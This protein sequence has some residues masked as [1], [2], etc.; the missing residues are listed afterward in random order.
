MR[1]CHLT[2]IR[3]LIQPSAIPRYYKKV[4]SLHIYIQTL[5]YS[6]YSSSMGPK[7]TWQRWIK[8]PLWQE[9]CIFSSISL[10][11]Y[12]KW[13]KSTLLI[14]CKISNGIKTARA[15]HCSHLAIIMQPIKCTFILITYFGC[16][17]FRV[18]ETC[19]V[20]LNHTRSYYKPLRENRQ[21]NW[22]FS[23]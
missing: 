13:N 9:L 6:M 3:T 8:M 12:K 4:L 21:E 1:L 5:I 17:V 2:Y 10:L 14:L 18:R 22:S 7:K 15:K 19:L 20:Y 16:M 11:K 23:K